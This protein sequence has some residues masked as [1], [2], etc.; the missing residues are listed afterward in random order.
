MEAD[1]LPVLIAGDG[2]QSNGYGFPDASVQ[3]CLM[4]PP[5]LHAIHAVV[6]NALGDRLRDEN[7]PILVH[8]FGGNNS[9][10]Q[11]LG[12]NLTRPTMV[13][14]N[15]LV[16]RFLACVH[17]RENDILLRYHPFGYHRSWHH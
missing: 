2:G 7:A 15:L 12:L 16:V 8:F 9:S 10:F 13:E 4:L 6:Q 1:G 14:N 11:E 17:F 5:S 3:H